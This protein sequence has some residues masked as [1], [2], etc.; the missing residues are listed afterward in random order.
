MGTPTSSLIISTYNWPEALELC[1]RSILLQKILPGEIIIA[2]D[3]SGPA[4]RQVVDRFKTV[5]PIPVKH[6]WHEDQGFR[7]AAIRNK[8]IAAA[9]G[10]YIVQIDGDILLHT[11]FIADHL[12]FAKRKSF[13]RASRIYLNDD[14]S[15]ELLLL[16]QSKVSI[17]NKGVTNKTSGIRLPFLWSFFETNYKNKGLER[18]EIHGCNMAFWKEDAI[19]ING[20]NEDFTGWGLEDKEFV[21]RMLNSGFEKRFLKLGGIVFHL[22]HPINPKPRLEHN[23]NL[24]KEAIRLQHTFC[25]NGVNKYHTPA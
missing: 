15:K 7:L 10:D 9:S 8:A 20:Y 24:L 19:A 1:L 11:Y 21:V 22:F 25:I 6:I 17:R 14:L 12:R 23:E 2:D 5:S 3:G 13:V 16:K 18:Y 4:T